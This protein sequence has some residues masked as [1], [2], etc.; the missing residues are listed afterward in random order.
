MLKFKRPLQVTKTP[1]ALHAEQ[2]NGKF[3]PYFNSGLNY[4]RNLKFLNF[5]GALFHKLFPLIFDEFIPYF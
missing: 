3:S 4:C 5:I 2:V 1:Y